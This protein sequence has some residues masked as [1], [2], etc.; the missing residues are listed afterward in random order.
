[1]KY[2]DFYPET[3]IPGW[4]RNRAE[5]LQAKTFL[6]YRDY[7]QWND[8]SWLE[9]KDDVDA[10][11]SFLIKSGI[12]AGDKVAI[13]SE[14]RPE[15]IMADLAVLS[16]GAADVT[17]YPTNS[18]SEAAHIINDSDS[19]IC[20]CA[21]SF[22]ADNL[23]RIKKQLPKLKKIIVFNDETYS[24]SKVVTLKDAL[25][26]G[27]KKNNEAEIDK[28]IRNINPDDLMTIMYTS[29]T[30]GDPKGVMLSVKN[31]TAQVLHFVRH[32]PHPTFETALSILPLSH[33]LERSIGY[34]LLLYCGGEVAFSRGTEFLIQDMAEIR[35]TCMISVPRLPEKM[36]EGIMTQVN[37]ASAVKQA[38]F[39][40][41][42]KTGKKAAPYFA[43]GS[44]PTGLLAKKYALASK[45]VL[46]KLRVTLGMDRMICMGTGGAPFSEEIHEFFTAMQV[47][48]L[49]G[50]GLTE[51][52]PVTHCHTHAHIMG[53]KKG[54]VGPPLP[55]TQCR[56]ED[57]G[58]ILIKAPQV[59]MGYY[60]NPEATAEVFTDDGWF[61]TG[62]IG[63]IDDEGYLRIT[64]RK[65]DII[66]T[67]GG[68][69]IAP[70]VIEGEILRNPLIEQ[71]TLIGDQ[72]KYITALIVPEFAGLEKWADD[73]GMAKS[74]REDL[75]K[76]PD[77][78]KLYQAMIDETNKALG[79]V[80]QVKK[81]TLMAEAFSPEKGE[82]TPTL[83]VK[84]KVVQANYQDIIEDMYRE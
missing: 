7:A 9:L 31:M 61:K 67:S 41:A 10:L 77:V 22:Q 53:I 19:L 15:W 58:E 21:G 66:I 18:D 36:Y 78:V 37:N 84:R 20:F 47:Y 44:A 12:K 3:S 43:G 70:Q 80:E 13:Y 79:R 64:D 82:V 54:T 73:K 17:I 11:A 1:M 4:F 57:D 42:V 28:R 24:D 27:R 8:I 69:N 35:P 16:V 25:A 56:I 48:V 6:R 65:K 34:N 76:Q 60:K 49:T 81:F 29:G 26:E 30:T 32:Q 23:L 40:W 2:S 74:S 52:A 63:M 72:R 68:K 59:M 62:D 14:N 38:L 45:L 33:A 55:L 5:V 50:Y 71:V 46:S 39:N 83:K 75:V 51:T